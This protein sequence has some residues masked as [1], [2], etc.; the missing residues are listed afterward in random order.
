M[1]AI[2][3][4]EASMSIS[5]R[6]R[7]KD[8]RVLSDNHFK[9]KAVTF[10]WRR[11]DG[12]WQTQRREI[13]DRGNGAA[14]LP[15]N[16]ARRTVVLVRQFRYQAYVNGCD[17][18]LIE[19]AA[20]MLDNESPEVRIRAEAEEETGYR[21]HDVRKIFEAFMSPGAMTEKLYFFVGEYE[22]EMKTGSGG[23]LREE[24]EDIEVLELSIDEALAMI[25]DG[26]IA[27]AKTIMLLQYAAL[28]VFR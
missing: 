1:A 4:L 22:P 21:L 27:D 6:I 24:G 28:H 9:V 3:R 10:E 8:E 18:L 7:V 15:Y 17:D 5:D 13:V 12:E 14:L 25:R 16:L 19:A 26:R 2:Q 20:G 23:G 11:S